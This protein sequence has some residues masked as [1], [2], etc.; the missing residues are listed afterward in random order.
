MYK[1]VNC[2][3]DVKVELN[4]ATKVQCTYCGYRIIEKKRP[5]ITKT[6]KAR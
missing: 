4:T 6:L 3:R 5:K 1:C 2:G